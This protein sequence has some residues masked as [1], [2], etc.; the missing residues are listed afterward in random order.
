MISYEEAH[1][2]YLLLSNAAA[3]HGYEVGLERALEIAAILVY[4][5]EAA[6]EMRPDEP[7]PIIMTEKEVQ[8]AMP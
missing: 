6:A 8:E 1:E 7:T 4:D 2:L 5:L 3:D